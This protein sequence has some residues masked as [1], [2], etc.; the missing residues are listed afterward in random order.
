MDNRITWLGGGL[1]EDRTKYYRKIYSRISNG[2]H[3]PAGDLQRTSTT[4]QEEGTDPEVEAQV[5]PALVK[6]YTEGSHTIT[7]KGGS[8]KRR[9]RKRTKQ[10]KPSL[11]KSKRKKSKRKKSKRKK[12]KR[13]KSKRKKTKRRRN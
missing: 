8:K 4:S 5:L 7:N 11:K 1:T 9:R 10:R 6:K 3:S 2:A 13:K 12:S